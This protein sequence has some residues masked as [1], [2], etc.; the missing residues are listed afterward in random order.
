MPVE[1]VQT[2]I[3]GGGQAGLAM[4]HRLKQRGLAHLVLERH[5]IAE[6]WRSE[7]WDGLRFQFPNWSVRLPDFPFPHTDPDG[8]ATS[9][10]ILDFIS[11]YAAFVAPPIRCGVAVTSLRC[12]DGGS[13]FIAETSDGPIEADNV[14]VATGPYQR[15]MTPA[16]LRDDGTVFQVHASRYTNPDQLPSGAVLVIGSGASGAQIAEELLCAGRRVYLSVGRHTRLP[17]RYRGRDLIWWLSAMGIDQTPVEARGPSRLLPVITGAYGGH[18]IDFRR[19]AADGVTLLGRLEAAREGVIDFAPDLV[20]SLA[21]G[22]AIYSTFLDMVD[23]HIKQHGLNMPED[24]AARAVLSD[25]LCVAEPLRRLDLRAAGVSAAIWAT[26][27]GVDF[28]WIGVPVL[29]AR[30]EP[31]HCGGVTDVPGLYF[32]GL[33]WLSKMSSSFLSG[34]GDDAA[35]LADHIVARS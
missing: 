8:F 32:L 34:V 6:R 17:R 15:P 14:V 19:F 12:R 27:Y 23:A 4:S 25:P 1:K 10:D 22:D 30:G 31:V 21:N 9:G 13:G 28:G 20:E 16:L 2:L 5:R 3:I 33:Q 26:G 18:T 7:R 29:D 35:V 11:A 24:P